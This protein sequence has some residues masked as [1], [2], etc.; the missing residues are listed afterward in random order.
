MVWAARSPAVRALREVLCRKGMMAA[1]LTHLRAVVTHSNYHRKIEFRSRDYSN[2]AE[3]WQ[4]VPYEKAL[5]ETER[6][7]LPSTTVDG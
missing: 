5:S 4:Y 6:L 7:V 1:A 2:K 3:I